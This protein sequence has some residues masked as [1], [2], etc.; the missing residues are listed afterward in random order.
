MSPFGVSVVTHDIVMGPLREPW[1]GAC[2]QGLPG[3]LYTDPAWVIIAFIPVTSG[4]APLRD[5][6]GHLNGS[7]GAIGTDL[8]AVF[9]RPKRDPA[10]IEEALAATSA[11]SI[12]DPEALKRLRAR[13]AA[14]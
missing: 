7:H 12:P 2:G 11:N 4:G 10:A 6:G 8:Q 1:G 14:R 5:Y 9:A 13:Q 3:D